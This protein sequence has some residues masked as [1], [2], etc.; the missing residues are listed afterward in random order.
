MQ[1]QEMGLG[2]A[3]YLVSEANG[4]RSRE[5]VTIAQGHKL[6][7]GTVLGKVEATGKY[8]PVD[9]ANGTGQGET[10]DGSQTAMAVL[11]AAPPPSPPP[12]SPPACWPPAPR[13]LRSTPSKPPAPPWTAPPAIRPWCRTP[14]WS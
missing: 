1:V 7:P 6:P 5:V 4:T 10:P 11:F 3:C 2:T 14:R 9:P 12:S 13:A 8:V